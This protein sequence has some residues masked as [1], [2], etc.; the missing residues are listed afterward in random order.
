[1]PLPGFPR[2]ILCIFAVELIA[3]ASPE[4]E[5]GLGYAAMAGHYF[6]QKENAQFMPNKVDDDAYL[7]RLP[8]YFAFSRA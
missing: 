4:S 1:M 6:G 2:E 8:T 5:W 7:V 3:R